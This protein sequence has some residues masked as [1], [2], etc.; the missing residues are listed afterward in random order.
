MTRPR[1]AVI[2]GT[3]LDVID[4]FLDWIRDQGVEPLADSSLRNASREQ[5]AEILADVE[6]VVGP[7]NFPFPEDLFRSSHPSRFIRLPQVDM[8]L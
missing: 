7:T 6:G 4:Q 3:C 1:L 8:T 2:N 5:L